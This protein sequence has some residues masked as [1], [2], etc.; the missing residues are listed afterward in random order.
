MSRVPRPAA[1]MAALAL[2]ACVVGSLAGQDVPQLC[3]AI[4]KVTVGQW[5]SYTVSGG[6]ALRFAIV[7]S[8][9]RGD[10]T[11]YWL[12]INDSRAGPRDGGI[13]Q[14]LVP[15]FGVEGVGVRG[16][17]M[18]TGTQPAMRLPDQML[19]LVGQQMVQN[20]PALGIARRCASAQ[21]VGWEKLTVPA[22]S[23][24]AL[25]VK[26]TEGEAWL[27]GD[28][29]FGIVKGHAKDGSEMVLTGRGVGARSS[30]TEKP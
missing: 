23:L 22:G 15:G 4:S 5:A 30:I 20:N 27:S 25:H 11:L 1:C 14:V 29:P 13:L 24:R 7:G 12:E 21:V 28:V 8:E 6:Q 18:K 16:M 26:D 17:V 19:A 10:T 2:G 9:Q 3:K